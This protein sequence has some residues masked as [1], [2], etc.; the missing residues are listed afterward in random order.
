MSEPLLIGIDVGT[1]AVKA[2]LFD[3]SGRALKTFADRYP[4]N[5]ARDGHVTQD[6]E[7][8]VQRCL[9]ALT[10]L[11]RGVLSGTVAAVGLTSQ[12]NTH[13]FVDRAGRPLLPAFVWQDGRCA[14]EAAQIDA[15][16]ATEDR[17]AWWGAPLPIDA[18]HVLSRMAFVALHHLDIW[19]QTRFVMAPKDYCIFRLTGVVA[20]DPLTAFGVVLGSRTYIPKLLDLVPGAAERLP[21]LLGPLTPS[22]G[23][24]KGL[25]GAGAP[26]V[27]GTMDAWA[28]LLGAGVARQDEAGYLSGT[29]EILGI[30]SRRKVP[31]PGVIAFPECEGI[32]LHAGPTQTGGASMAWLSRLL[33]RSPAELSVLVESSPSSGPVPLFLPHLAGERAPLWDITSRAAFAGMSSATGPADLTRAV[34]EGVGYS[35]RLL[36]ESLERSADCRPDFLRIAGGGTQSDAWCQIRADILSRPLRRS[37]HRDTGTLGAAMLAGVGIGLFPSIDD[38]ARRLAPI[39]RVFEPRASEADR[40]AFGFGKYQELYYQLKEFNAGF[41]RFTA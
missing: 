14:A 18:S 15:K 41:C 27:T 12:V 31:T 39:G 20:T 30:V 5:R 1:T 24:A 36:L 26:M 21:P 25:P 34:M 11:T 17:L 29:S 23:I 19:R 33:G 3:L 32:V 38:A 2:G 35:A 6:P 37:A 16:V 7:D 22:G 28:G 4:T 13:V 40:H 8:W 9:Q 10:E